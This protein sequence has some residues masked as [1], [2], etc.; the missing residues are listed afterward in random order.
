MRQTYPSIQIAALLLAAGL[1]A[2]CTERQLS[3]RPSDGPLTIHLTWPEGA[4]VG[5]SRL[6]LYGSDGSLR[7]TLDASAAGYEGR[8][9]ADTYTIL[10]A[11]A[12]G[13]QVTNAGT[14]SATTNR[15]CAETEEEDGTSATSR[16]AS[17]ATRSA[18]TRTSATRDTGTTLLRHVGNAYCTGME[19]VT[20]RAGNTSTEVTLNTVNTVRVVRFS[21]DPNYIGG[22]AD[23]QVR[24]TGIVP[25]V[26]VMDGTDAGYPTGVVSATAFPDASG[27]YLADLSVF[28]WRGDNVVSVTVT[29]TDGSTEDTV[30]QDISGQ[31]QALPAEGGTVSLTLTLPDGG[32]ISLVLIVE[33]WKE[34]S[35]GGTII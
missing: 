14:E 19:S 3:E 35:G 18:T 29:Y 27:I 20:V 33:A 8:V 21:L 26:R 4:E 23:M 15:L 31:L 13:V 16:N 24:V 9:T 2:G 22:I 30:P 28:G 10:A 17:V 12:D 25:S 34:G 32:E 1:C 6:W 5:S 7:Y 11:N